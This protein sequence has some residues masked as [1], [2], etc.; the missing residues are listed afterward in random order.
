M[1]DPRL[2]AGHVEERGLL[3]RPPDYYEKM[4]AVPF[5][6]QKVISIAP[7]EK[8]VKLEDG[9]QLCYG[10]LL[11]ATGASPVHYDIEGHDKCGVHVL[12]TV[13]E[14]KAIAS[15][16]RL[17]KRAVILGGGLV[18]MKSADALHSIGMDVTVVVSSHQLLSQTMDHTGAEIVRQRVM[19][20]GIKVILGAKIS[21]IVGEDHVTGVRLADGT[22]LPCE[23]VISAKGVRPNIGL[24]ES[25]GIKV[26]YGIIVDV[27]MRT[28]DPNIY[29]AGDVAEGKDLLS[30]GCFVHAIWPN[31]MEQ[32]RIAGLNMSGQSV[33]YP[34]GIGMNSAEFFGLPCISAGLCRQNEGDG[35]EILTFMD[36]EHDKY[37]KVVIR[38]GALVGVVMIGDIDNAGVYTNLIM[39]RASVST[40][41]DI[42]VHDDFDYAKILAA[43][44][45]EDRGNYT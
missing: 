2:I 30:D 3:F 35:L 36:K 12:R 34:G 25:A 28:S 20:Q 14:A 7:S 17:G 24:A 11:L 22:V 15:E 39:K 6:G 27:H 10:K 18:G 40:I 16:A 8:M 37:R 31:A 1:L 9:T 21:A 4:N 43:R 29:A 44:V 13:Q 26:D 19:E 32:G 38:D 23:I 33:E 45:L 42:L 5:L 41:K